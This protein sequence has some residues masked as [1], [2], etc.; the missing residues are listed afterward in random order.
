MTQ[1]NSRPHGEK[2]FT[3]HQ[4]AMSADGMDNYDRIFGKK[5][6]ISKKIRKPE[7]KGFKGNSD[8]P[9]K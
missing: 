3:Y 1:R 2:E 8:R 5:D 6:F 9:V 7:Q 4:R